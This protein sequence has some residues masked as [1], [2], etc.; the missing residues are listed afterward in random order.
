MPARV[1]EVDRIAVAVA[2]RRLREVLVPREKAPKR[3]VVVPR[4]HLRQGR[5]TCRPEAIRA[6][7][8]AHTPLV[9][10]ARAAR[11]RQRI[12]KRCVR[13]RPHRALPA[14]GR[15]PRRAQTVGNRRLPAAHHQA[16][17]PQVDP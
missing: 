13:R 8:A 14:V 11:R 2:I 15:P 1:S 6:V 7:A 9:C 10:A 3:R 12:P 5:R 4:T 16:V 17:P